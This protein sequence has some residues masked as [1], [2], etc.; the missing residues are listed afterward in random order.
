MKKCTKCRKDK[1]SKD[2]YKN[3]SRKDGLRSE[4]KGCNKAAVARYQQ[5]EKGKAVM[6]R[7]NSSAERKAV[8]ARYQQSPKGKAYQARYQQSPEGKAS[9]AEYNKK[10]LSTPE[11][12][13][14]RKARNAVYSAVRAGKLKKEPCVV[15][16]LEKSEGH[17]ESYD[18]PLEVIWLC[19]TH[20]IEEH[21]KLQPRE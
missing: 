2:F 13:K 19:R 16:G 5:T 1:D 6:A 17:H 21:L 15:C 8:K 11:G 14:K 12:Q 10:R 4:C 20:H 7:Y 9:A 3:K 18:K